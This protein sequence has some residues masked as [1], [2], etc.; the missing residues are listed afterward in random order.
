MKPHIF[1]TSYQNSEKQQEPK[2]SWLLKKIIP[3]FVNGKL[4][5]Y[6]VKTIFHPIDFVAFDGLNTGDVKRVCL[7]D[8]KSI[9][10]RCVSIQQ[11][12]SDTVKSDAIEWKT[13]R[14]GKTGEI[15]ID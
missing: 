12:I 6:D 7:V 15:T 13:V 10:K 9:D 2:L 5:A 11:S 3:T 4:D 14:I 8:K 1:I